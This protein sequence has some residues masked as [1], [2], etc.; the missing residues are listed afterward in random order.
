M[1]KK[2]PNQKVRF[3][4]LFCG[5]GGFRYAVQKVAENRGV[6]CECVF[7][8]DIDPYCQLAYE[9]NFGERPTGDISAVDVAEIPGHDLL[10]A[11]FP[12]QPFSI[13]GHMKGFGDTRGTLFF[14][15]ARIIAAKKPTAFVLEN[16]KLL[17]GH[18]G[19]KTLRVILDTLKDLG[20]ETGF[21]VLNALDFG[22]PQKRER[23]WIVGFK[24]DVP[25]EWPCGKMPMMPL[26][27][28]LEKKVDS[29]HYAS[30]YI[31]KKRLASMKPTKKTTIWH[32]N[33]AGNISALPY[34][35][36]LRAGASYNY[37]LV[38]GERRL[39]PREMLRL[40][41]FPESFKIVCSDCQTRR[42]A[43]NSLPVNVAEA[44]LSQVFSALEWGRIEYPGSFGRETCLL[45]TE[46]KPYEATKVEKR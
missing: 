29:R 3:I 5:I 26:E 39:T 43:G 10:L 18:D 37:L 36:A 8:S 15:I 46:E 4:D 31:R 42:Q 1:N 32:E 34:S 38:D 33:K 12:C 24:D 21:R 13:I 2:D 17:R 6:G 23:I 35:C 45:E 27:K 44:V 19:G 41:G 11:G 14:E 28:L 9:K 22:L 40:Q 25:M 20:Y 16:V 30:G 7:S